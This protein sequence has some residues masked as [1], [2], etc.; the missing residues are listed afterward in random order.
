MSFEDLCRLLGAKAPG[1]DTYVPSPFDHEDSE[2]E[3]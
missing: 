2:D 1:L 3:D